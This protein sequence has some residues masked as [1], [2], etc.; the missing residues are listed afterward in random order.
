MRGERRE[1]KEIQRGRE[2]Y[3][4]TQGNVNRE[5]QR[6]VR[7]GERDIERWRKME[8]DVDT[9]RKMERD[10]DKEIERERETER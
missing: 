3:R 10:R 9:W 1:V 8:R 2:G 6:E 7:H 4:G 5:I